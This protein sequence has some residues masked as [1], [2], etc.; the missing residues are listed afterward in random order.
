[1]LRGEIHSVDLG[2]GRGRERIGKHFAVVVSDDFSNSLQWTIVIVPGVDAS[3]SPRLRSGILIPASESRA[4]VDIRFLPIHIRSVDSSRFPSQPI[5][6]VPS[7]R[8]VDLDVALKNQ[9]DLR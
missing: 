1:M 7:A 5:G 6:L 8:M 4:P 3:Q 9:L 2:K